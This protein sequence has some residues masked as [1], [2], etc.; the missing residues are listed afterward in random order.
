MKILIAV[1]LTMIS[2]LAFFYYWTSINIDNINTRIS[3]A[4]VLKLESKLS[5]LI[6]LTQSRAIELD[7]LLTNAN[8]ASSKLSS[9]EL[10]LKNSVNYITSSSGTLRL[11]K[12]SH[13]DLISDGKCDRKRGIFEQ[14]VHFGTAFIQPP[15]VVLA[16]NGLDVRAGK[17]ARF[18]SEIVNVDK[19]GFT[20]NAYT[21]CDT[22]VA[23]AE[24]TWLAVGV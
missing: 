6:Q 4:K 9:I 18:K 16:I 12:S 3:E 7:E 22:S 19:D 8:L 14:K 24:L 21:W 17:D 2:L 20:F 5:K 10:K 1:N 15:D 23:Y 11:D 13:T